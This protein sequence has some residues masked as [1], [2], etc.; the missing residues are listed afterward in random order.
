MSARETNIVTSLRF[1]LVASPETST[2][3]HGDNI[4]NLQ[5]S[6]IQPGILRRARSFKCLDFITLFKRQSDLR[7]G[8]P[9]RWGE[10]RSGSQGRQ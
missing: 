7:K 3:I 8:I 6:T 4:R 1:C 2:R 9:R 5:G 10:P